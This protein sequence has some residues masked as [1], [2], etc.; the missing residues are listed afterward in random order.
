MH[1]SWFKALSCILIFF[2]FHTLFPSYLPWF[3]VFYKLLNIL[4]DYTT[5]GQVL[6]FYFLLFNEGTSIFMILKEAHIL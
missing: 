6:A 3:E 5:K 1:Q 2:C 4:A